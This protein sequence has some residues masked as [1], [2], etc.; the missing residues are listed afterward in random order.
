MQKIWP[1]KTMNQKII[2]ILL[3]ILMGVTA[4][5]SLQA[6]SAILLT[7]SQ[8]IYPLGPQ[9]QTLED[10][11]K[12]W[13]IEDV[14]GP[15]LSGQ[16]VPNEEESLGF[17]FTN[18]AI[19]ARFQAQNEADETIPWLLAVDSY[20]FFIDVY[21]PAANGQGYDVTQTGS[22]RPYDTRAIDH[23]RFLF[24]LSLEPGEEQTIYARFESES[25]MNLSLAI[26]S[27][28]AV[29]QDDLVT[30]VLNGTLYG[31]LLIMAAYN[32]ILFLTLRDRSYFFYA[33]FLT[34]LLISYLIN[35]SV[36]HKYIWPGQ[37][38]INAIGGQV[39][40]TLLLIFI[41]LFTNTFLRLKEYAPRL[42]KGLFVVIGALCL[43]LPL[44]WISILWSS[45]PLLILTLI[46]FVVVVAG[47]VLVWRKGYKPA[48]Y[49]LLAWLLLLSSFVL[50]V[51]SLAGILPLTLFSIA[52]SE[53][54]I[55]VL[56]LTLSLALADRISI[57]RE[58][59]EAAQGELLRNQEEFTESLRQANSRLEESFEERTRELSFAQEQINLL[60]ENSP[61]SIGTAAMDGRV[62]TANTAMKT[63]FGYPDDDIFEANVFDFFPDD[64]IRREIMDQL[65]KKGLIREPVLQLQRSDGTLIYANLTESILSRGDQDVLLGI[66]DD[67]TDQVIT[68]QEL[69]K[70]AEDAAVAEERNR[71]ARELHD[72]VTQTLYTTSL[73]AE[74]L[75]KVWLTHP[76]E[77]LR[78]LRELRI[79]TQGALAEMRTLLLE[80]RPGELV[81]R[82]LSELLHQLTDAMSTRTE[83]PI[84]T[85]VIGDATLPTDVKIAFFRITQEALNNISKHARADRAWVNLST[86][87]GQATLRIGDN[88]RGFQLDTVPPHRLGLIIMQE[89]AKAIE[90]DF[91]LESAADVG[92]NIIVVWH[93]PE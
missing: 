30:Q 38:R 86:Q 17:G 46:T 1:L 66:V 7:D 88:G 35:D 28:T 63:L 71:I 54:G 29:A 68:E 9:L 39:S 87:N 26:W 31:V 84:T 56:V 72:S 79:L 64:E 15:E 92:T 2:I 55:L 58:D 49:F 67:I 8:E 33:I 3:F 83:M 47:S 90:A 85:T 60:F 13:T 21:V 91:S 41:L 80:L 52:G 76:E 34:T 81:D 6:Q 51:L 18:S 5:L 20:L 27:A 23:P 45:R 57:Y 69:Q 22:A 59:R 61:L 74:A 44:Q 16:F 48:R 93:T 75:P 65:F 14:T 53:I 12:T 32:F 42:Q 40:F 82:S 10:K 77:A 89:R 62:L 37:G 4:P 19:W 25:A 24:N 78:S 50:F 43:L 36:A 11:E 73:I 70:K